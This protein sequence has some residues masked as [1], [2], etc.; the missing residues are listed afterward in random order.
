M[1][2]RTRV[3][4]LERS[5]ARRRSSPRGRET[6]ALVRADRSRAMTLAGLTPDPW[7][8]DLLSNPSP[9][10]LALCSRQSGKSQTAAADVLA[11]VLAEPGALALILSPTV[12]QSVELFRKVMAL[13]RRLGRPVRATVENRTTLELA[14]GSRVVALP[15]DPDRVVGYSAPRLI[16]ID[17]AARVRDELYLAVRPMLAVGRGRLLCCSTPFGR[18]GFF[19]DAWENGAD[20]HR[21]RVSAAEVPRIAPAFLAEERRAL[22]PRWFAQEYECSFEDATDAVFSHDDVMAALAGWDGPV[23]DPTLAA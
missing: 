13:Y 14:N 4:S 19:F 23:V 9:R 21:V 12:R 17:E 11:T 10:V 16:V 1:N 5:R 6:L 2:L 18:R 7:Q 20:W 15:G 3:A 8:A 22:G